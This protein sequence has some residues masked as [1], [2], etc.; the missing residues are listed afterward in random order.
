[1]CRMIPQEP[2]QTHFSFHRPSRDR[3][4]ARGLPLPLAG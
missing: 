2:A 1:L 3:D 4:I